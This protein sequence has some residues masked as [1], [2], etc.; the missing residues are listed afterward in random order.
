MKMVKIR[1]L[2]GLMVFGL[3]FSVGFGVFMNS[4]ALAQGQGQGPQGPPVFLIAG[5]CLP[6]DVPEPENRAIM[7]DVCNP[8]CD[9]FG[10]FCNH[11]VV[12]RC[13]SPNS[14][15]NKRPF[16]PGFACGPPIFNL[17]DEGF[18]AYQC[19]GFLDPRN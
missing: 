15:Q 2:I 5:L 13:P 1:T 8:I 6:D 18:I 14:A 12:T 9:I 4:D 16:G 19:S 10:E 17:C 11:V 7:E 3:V